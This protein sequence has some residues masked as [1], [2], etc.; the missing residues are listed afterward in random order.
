MNWF[1]FVLFDF[2]LGEIVEVFG[3]VGGVVYF[4]MLFKVVNFNVGLCMI[5]EYY[6]IYGIIFGIM[7]VVIVYLVV[8][9]FFVFGKYIFILIGFICVVFFYVF[10]G[11]GIF[12]D[13]IG[14]V[15]DEMICILIIVF[16]VFIFIFGMMFVC[17]FFEMCKNLL[18]MDKLFIV[19]LILCGFI[20]VLVILNLFF[21]YFLISVLSLI[22]V[23]IFIVNGV[24]VI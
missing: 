11:L 20:V 10:I 12:R 4:Y 16:V 13:V 19:F 5:Y 7:L 14:Y 8:F 3:C 21:G 22:G 2:V 15:G 24:W 23:L 6:V 1:F 9:W 18:M 17:L